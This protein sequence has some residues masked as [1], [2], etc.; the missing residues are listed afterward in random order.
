[1]K[2][3]IIIIS[4]IFIAISC[5]EE[6]DFDLNSDNNSRLVISGG[7]TTDTI[8]HKILLTRTSSYYDTE[9]PAVES[10]ADVSISDGTNTFV[11]TENSSQL[12]LYETDSTVF[13]EVGKTYKLKITTDDGEVYEASSELLRVAHIDSAGYIYREFNTPNGKKIFYD[14][15]FFAQEPVGLGDNYLFNIYIQDS[16]GNYILDNDTLRETPFDND[17]M[18]DGLYIPGI[19]FYSLRPHEIKKDSIN[20]K[21]EMQSMTIDHFEYNM[22]LMMETS[23]KGGPFDGPPANIPTNIS[24]GALGYFRASASSSYYFTLYKK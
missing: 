17:M 21:I 12:G 16:I 14:L 1:M 4:V 22:A 13:G 23:Y 7:I 6:I 19:R 10:N 18:I 5:T 24:N 3:I 20:I 9:K 15:I 11:L 2:N 8:V